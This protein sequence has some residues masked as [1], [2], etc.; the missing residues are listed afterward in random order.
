MWCL[1]HT[2][3]LTLIT[4]LQ[5]FELLLA[6]RAGSTR[7]ASHNRLNLAKS[8]DHYQGPAVRVVRCFPNLSRREAERAVAEG[9]VRVDGQVIKPGYRL[10]GGQTLTLGKK[11]IHW[12]PIACALQL[13]STNN[14]SSSQSPSS[15]LVYYKYHKPVGVACTTDKHDRRGLWHSLPKKFRRNDKPIFPVGRLDLDS[16]GLVL[17][18]NDGR[19]ANDLLQP[20]YK[21]EKEYIVTVRPPGLTA[22][23]LQ[24]LQSGVE[25]TTRQQRGGA[26]TTG[27]TRPCIVEALDKSKQTLRFVLHEGRN[28][29]IR[30]MVS[31]L[32]SDVTSLKR[33][34]HGVLSLNDLPSGMVASVGDDELALLAAS[35]N[36][37]T[38]NKRQSFRGHRKKN[39]HHRQLRP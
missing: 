36:Q 1:L 29:Q 20:K 18:T 10:V 22:E 23:D 27:F 39:I 3:S 34:R 30:K 12:E 28:R 13:E 19:L 17:L 33:I 9:H 31:A 11:K 26:E 14:P 38:T 7:T 15:S 37:H 5:L 32:G 21:Q 25:I 16:E 2:S 24:R 4:L 6:F 8:L 35:V